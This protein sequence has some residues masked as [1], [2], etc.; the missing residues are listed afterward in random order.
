MNLIE[1]GTRREI[2]DT[3]T[4]SGVLDNLYVPMWRKERIQDAV[5]LVIRNYTED[6]VQAKKRRVIEWAMKNQHADK[7]MLADFMRTV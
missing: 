1:P 3:T 2:K 5:K 4:L 7:E 6:E